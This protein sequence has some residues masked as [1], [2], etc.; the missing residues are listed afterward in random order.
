M[1]PAYDA[2]GRAVGRSL[3]IDNIPSKANPAGERKGASY[4]PVDHTP[5][6]AIPLFA[7]PEPGL[8]VTY[9]A[10]SSFL[11]FWLTR[12]GYP[13][14]PRARTLSAPAGPRPLP[15]FA[16]TATC[17]RG[18][19][20]TGRARRS[21]STSGPCATVSRRLPARLAV[22]GAAFLFSLRGP[23]PSAG[24]APAQAP[25]GAAPAA[26]P[27]SCIPAYSCVFLR[28]PGLELLY[29]CVFLRIPA[30][31]CVFLC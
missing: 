30:Y 21:T 27:P 28:I 4:F 2:S 9:S 25:P 19:W 12:A 5:K 11:H 14:W 16:P 6:S 24:C 26:R 10:V 23:A 18:S 3:I 29:S 7:D 8:E 17:S 31:S 20:G 13:S 22:R 15:T 1:V